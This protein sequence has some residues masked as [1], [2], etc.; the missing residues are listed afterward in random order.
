MSLKSNFLYKSILTIVNPLIGLLI[1]PYI[2]R[3]LGVQNLGLVDFVDNTINYFLLFAMM[4]IANIGVRSIASNKNNRLL[5]NK[6]FSNLLGINLSFTVVLLAIYVVSI[7]LIPRFN[8]YAEL[9]YI[10][11]AKILFSTLLIEWFFTGI[12]EFRYITLRTLVIKVLYVLC[13]FLMVKS[14]DDYI[15]YFVLTTIVIVVNALINLMYSRNFVSIQFNELFSCRFFKENITVGIY[16]IMTS[17][18]LT[19]NV[20]FLGLMTDTVQV[21]YYSS[22][23]KLYALV[24]GL[25]SA[26]TNVMLPRMSSL[27]ASDDIQLYNTYIRNSF[28]FVA[29]FSIPIIICS[30]ILAPELIYLLCG[31][32]YQGAILP[33]RIIMPAILLVG[34]AQILAIQVLMTQKKDKVLLVASIIGAIVSLVVNVIFVSKLG[35]VGSAIVLLSAELVVTGTYLIYTLKA[36]MV[37]IPWRLFLRPLVLTMPCA[38]FCLLSKLF[39]E[40]IYLVLLV[41]VPSSIIFYMM[42]NFKILKT[43]YTSGGSN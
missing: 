43:Y 27:V 12:E 40:N 16:T 18:Y 17:M 26:F 39:I 3:T 33:M 41:A 28:D 9:F 37:V 21:G 1:F 32:G 14:S 2:S 13:V 42:A 5:L 20:M 7:S 11:S 6:T 38:L 34:I 15:T 30:S 25:F 36:R 24:L 8:L 4:G 31:D 22:A 19:F 23:Y 10:G 35:S 29:L